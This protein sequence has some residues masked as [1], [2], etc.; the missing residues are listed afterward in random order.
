MKT[1]AFTLTILCFLSFVW[2]AYFHF[3][4]PDTGAQRGKKAVSVFVG[5]AMVIGIAILVLSNPPHRLTLA[6]S[7]PVLTLALFVFW[8]SVK[9]T[10]A[11]RLEFLGST[12][13]PD[14]I[15]TDGPYRFVR[16]PFYTSYMLAWAGAACAAGNLWMTLISA[17]MI[18]LY[19]TAAWREERKILASSKSSAYVEYRQK[20]GMLL[21][22]IRLIGRQT[23][24]HG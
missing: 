23:G 8:W 20:T 3:Q 11:K 2:G 12:R 19:T 15:F 10:R 17:A 16:H 22:S 5:S 14:D 6:V 9:A 24:T 13:P 1:A 21:P 7:L 18:V 4:S